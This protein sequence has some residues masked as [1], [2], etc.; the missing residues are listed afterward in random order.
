MLTRDKNWA[1]ANKMIINFSKTEEIVFRRP[2]RRHFINP[3]PINNFEQVDVVNLL[4]ILLSNNFCFDAQVGNVL[5]MCSQW[6]YLLKVREQGLSRGQLHTVFLELIV[7]RL[8]Y[9]LPSWSG[10]LSR[11]QIGQINTFLKRIY[12]CGFSCELIQL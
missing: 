3:T 11:K 5:K 7:S 2:G 4:G 6:V 9:A 10:F 1:G 12:R 8:R